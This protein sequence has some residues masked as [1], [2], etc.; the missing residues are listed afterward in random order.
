M[1][2]IPYEGKVWN[3]TVKG[4]PTFLTPIGMTHNTVKPVRIMETLLADVPTSCLVVD[5]FFGSGTTGV[6]CLRTG[7]DL[8]GIE[9]DPSHLTISDQRVRY[10]ARNVAGWNSPKI[11]SEAAPDLEEDCPVGLGALFELE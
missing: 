7:H 3:L 8:I 2:K 4:S 5:P 9:Q 6:A 10:W 1:R 11:I